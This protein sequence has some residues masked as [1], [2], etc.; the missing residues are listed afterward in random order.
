MSVHDAEYFRARRRKLGIPERDAFTAPR[1]VERGHELARLEGWPADLFSRVPAE[2]QSKLPPNVA[3]A[4]NCNREHNFRVSYT[5]RSLYGRGWQLYYFAS[6]A[7]KS[8]YV[9]ENARGQ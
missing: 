8:K 4:C 1:F 6:E 5:K 7:C 9:R 3:C 2:A